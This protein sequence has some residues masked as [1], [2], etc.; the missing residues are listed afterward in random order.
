MDPWQYCSDF[1]EVD[2]LKETLDYIL[3]VLSRDIYPKPL[4]LFLLGVGWD[5]TSLT[6]GVMLSR[7]TCLG[8]SNVSGSYMC[9]LLAETFKS[10]YVAPSS[11]HL[12]VTSK[13]LGGRGPVSL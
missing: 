10:L 9:N 3:V 8:Q 6:L 12:T 1:A 4:I 11:F 7:M 5:C 13:A 2:G